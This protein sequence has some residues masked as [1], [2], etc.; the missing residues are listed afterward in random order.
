MNF[1]Q[2][3]HFTAQLKLIWQNGAEKVVINHVQLHMQMQ[4]M[5]ALTQVP[6]VIPVNSCFAYRMAACIAACRSYI[7]YIIFLHYFPI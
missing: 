3:L 1:P 5:M 6:L 7:S 4:K 2:T